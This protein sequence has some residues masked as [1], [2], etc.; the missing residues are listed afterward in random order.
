MATLTANA[1][2]ARPGGELSPTT[3]ILQQLK[4]QGVPLTADN[5]RRAVV[6]NARNTNQ[7]GPDPVGG[8][9]A[10]GYET[11][12]NYDPTPSPGDPGTPQ[13]RKR[14]VAKKIEGPSKGYASASPDAART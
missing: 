10:G 9:V 5:I 14:S 8:P 1:D 12:R 6:A 11:V 4:R 2:E 13:A 7:A 3:I